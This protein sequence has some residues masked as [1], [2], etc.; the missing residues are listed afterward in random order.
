MVDNDSPDIV[1]DSETWLNSL[2]LDNE[3]M[4]KNYKPYRRD[5]DDGYGGVLIGVTL[6]WLLNLLTLTHFV[7]CVLLVYVCLIVKNLLWLV[8]VDPLVEILLTNRTYVN[9]SVIL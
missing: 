5:H 6:L 3:I 1:I 4:P 2:I 9:V 8:C 7:K